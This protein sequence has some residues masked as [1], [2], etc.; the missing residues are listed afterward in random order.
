MNRATFFDIIRNDLKP[1]DR[2]TVAGIEALLDAGKYLPLH[3]MANVLAQV[4]RETGDWMAPIK[5]TV[6]PWHKNKNPTDAEVIRR[7]DRAFAAGKLPWVKAP[8]WRDGEFGRG[9]IQLTHAAN[10]AKFG[11]SKRDDLLKMPVS[12]HVAVTGMRMGLFTGHKL[13]DYDFP[14]AI[15]NPPDD[16]P[17]RIVNGR[18]GSDADVAASHVMFAAAL[19]AGGWGH[20]TETPKS[21]HVAPVT[22]TR[23]VAQEPA[24]SERQSGW[25]ARVKM[26]F[27]VLAAIFRRWR[28]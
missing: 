24:Q 5:E 20:V 18:D 28:G 14:G 27:G 6:M 4:R 23:V 10:R 17:R 7:L 21:E 3:H 13:G 9:Q 15:H 22:L 12:A 26:F 1:L 8:Y 25:L 16:N 11:I 19:L 2:E